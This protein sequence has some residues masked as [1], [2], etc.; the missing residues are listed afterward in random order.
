M[1]KRN[2]TNFRA[3]ANSFTS[4]VDTIRRK[5]YAKMTKQFWWQISDFS[6]FSWNFLPSYFPPLRSLGRRGSSYQNLGM[7]LIAVPIKN[8]WRRS[9]EHDPQ[10]NRIPAQNGMQM[11]ISWHSMSFYTRHWFWV[12][13]ITQHSWVL[14]LRKID[15]VSLN[16]TLRNEWSETRV[17]IT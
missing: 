9:P 11:R 15:R 10:I 13:R 5:I 12:P 6:H 4:I 16:R 14:Y 8:I 7:E 3:N 2:A 1:N 17:F